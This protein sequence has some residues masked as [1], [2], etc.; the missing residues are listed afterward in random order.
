MRSADVHP[1]ADE[2]S[3]FLTGRLAEPDLERVAAHLES[4]PACREALPA[5]LPD[6]PLLLALRQPLG[7]EPCA[8]EA[9]CATTIERLTAESPSTVSMPAHSETA[10]FRRLPT[11]ATPPLHPGHACPPAFE[12][13]PCD[14]GRY[15]ILRRLGQGGMGSVYLAEDTLLQRRVALKVSHFDGTDRDAEERFRRE[16]RAAAAL[17]HEGICPVFDYGVEGDIP[18]ITM[19]YIEGRSL[20]QALKEGPP[21]EPNWA[22]ELVRQ[23]ALAL[24]EAHRRGVLHRDLKPANILLDERGRAKVVDFGLARRAEDVTLTRPGATA[25]TPAYMSP[26][27]VRGEPLTAATDIYTLG[28]ILYQLLAG[29]LPYPGASMTELSYQIVHA[30]P[31]PPSA[32]REGVDPHLDAVC[33]RAMAKAPADRY[34]TMDELAGD[35][36]AYLDGKSA[37]RP[38]PRPRRLRWWHGAVAAAVLLPLVALPFLWPPGGGDRGPEQLADNGGTRGTSEAGVG[39]MGA[40]H[41]HP[42]PPAKT[43]GTARAKVGAGKGGGMQPGKAEP[44]EGWIDVKV[45][46]D[47]NPNRRGAGLKYGALPLRADDEISVHA[48]L[49]RPAYA[50]L[51]WIEAEGDVQPIYPWRPGHWDE[52]PAEEKRVR[53]LRLPDPAT[54][55]SS[56]VIKE[57]PAGMETLLLLVREDSPLPRDVDL[58]ALLSGLGKQPRPDPRSVVY[59]EDFRPI[60]GGG[61]RGPNLFDVSRRDDP[62][63]ATQRE[64]RR[65]LGNLFSYSTAASFANLGK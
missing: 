64:L 50:Y 1:R 48:G 25:G 17:Q 28:V 59:F 58:K 34:A 7:P 12:R 10:S 57:G 63:V 61:K 46:E 31:K 45:W 38:T 42:Q 35:L 60:A 37:R 62:V 3:R 18:F 13:L 22:A 47:G 55:K 6:D 2:L 49:T 41:Q 9:A 11:D 65:R 19:A 21:P 44:L 52:R 15:R 43:G 40:T 24:A 5:R 4:C 51:L 14:F 39:S 27:Q 16:A 20:H 30:E 36:Q 33:G 23:V 53:E 56:W 54:G 8:E 32:R 26:E 29:G